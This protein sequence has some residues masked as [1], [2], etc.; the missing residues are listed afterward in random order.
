MNLAT[1]NVRSADE[2]DRALDLAATQLA[3]GT[4]LLLV[5]SPGGGATMFAR[6]LWRT[7]GCLDE[8]TKEIVEALYDEAGLGPRVTTPFRAPHHSCSHAA[9]LGGGIKPRPGEVSLAHAGV[10]FLDELPEF[11]GRAIA[12]LG[13]AVRAGETRVVRG[14]GARTFPARPRLVVSSAHPCPCGFRGSR[15][16]CGCSD[17]TLRRFRRRVED[18]ANAMSAATLAI[19]MT[20]MPDNEIREFAARHEV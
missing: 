19:D 11:Q 4:H 1:I 7:L 6:R 18:Y 15:Y 5:E 2:A 3:E 16:R 14:Q 20:A 8:R 9:L 10:L 17:A 12:S 13:Q